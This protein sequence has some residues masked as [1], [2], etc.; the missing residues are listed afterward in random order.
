MFISEL[1]LHKTH[2]QTAEIYNHS[3]NKQMPMAC[4]ISCVHAVLRPPKDKNIIPNSMTKSYKKKI[5]SNFIFLIPFDYLF[6][7]VFLKQDLAF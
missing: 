5:K 7:C 4:M 6:F 3:E 2:L 1:V